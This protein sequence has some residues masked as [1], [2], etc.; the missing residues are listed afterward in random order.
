MLRFML[1]T[2]EELMIYGQHFS[3]LRVEYIIRPNK[4]LRL[5]A[6][7]VGDKS[8]SNYRYDIACRIFDNVTDITTVNLLLI[9][10]LECEIGLTIG[11]NLQKFRFRLWLIVCLHCRVPLKIGHAGRRIEQ[12][13]LIRQYRLEM[14]GQRREVPRHDVPKDAV[15]HGN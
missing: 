8:D 9:P 15:V 6:D 3:R 2:P 10:P 4:V 12:S 13:G 7:H 11:G 5:P 1:R 14:E